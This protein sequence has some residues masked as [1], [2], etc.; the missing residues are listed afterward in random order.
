MNNNNRINKA[1]AAKATLAVAPRNTARQIV[2]VLQGGGALG[3]YQAALDCPLLPAATISQ[4]ARLPHRPE[5]EISLQPSLRTIESPSPILSIWIAHQ[6]QTGAE[7]DLAGEN[8]PQR[9]AL[10]RS[11]G[12][13]KLA[14][15][16]AGTAAFYQRLAR[17]QG[18]ENAIAGARAADPFF[19]LAA[20][21][22]SMSDDGLIAGLKNS[23]PANSIK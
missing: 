14:S 21:L 5:F 1:T 22:A 7:I 20:V 17:G 10:W 3:A 9:V 16:E 12:G 6:S 18:L 4:L 13:I 23:T 8:T 2:L 15:I 11:G 19:D